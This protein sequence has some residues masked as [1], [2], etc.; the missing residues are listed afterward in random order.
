MS[1]RPVSR[2]GTTS[3]ASPSS[4]IKIT[5]NR[6]SIH[7][8]ALWQL[9]NR[10]GLSH[11][12]DWHSLEGGDVLQVCLKEDWLVRWLPDKDTAR[13]QV[14]PEYRQSP[15]ALR[16]LTEI[17][18][19]MLA[20]PFP[21]E[22]TS[23]DELTMHLE[24]RAEIAQAA[25]KTEM[26]F[27]TEAIHRPTQ[28][29]SYDEDKGFTLKA[30][31]DLVEA[32]EFTTQ[33]AL[34][35]ERFSFSCY[36]ATEYVILLGIS[37]VLRQK[38]PKHYTELLQQWNI[39]P[40]QSSRFH[41]HFLLESGSLD[42]PFPMRFYTPGD[43]VWFKNPDLPSSDVAGYEGSWVIYLGQGKFTN[44]WNKQQPF[45]LMT[46][47]VEVYHWRDGLSSNAVGMATIDETLVAQEVAK[48]LQNQDRLALIA[49]NMMRYRDPAGVYAQGGCIDA[50]RE[51]PI[52]FASH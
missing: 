23:L 40:L 33:P 9:F 21:T 51:A 6:Q 35:G 49:D 28:F 43:R 39:E 45:S 48:T 19:C 2:P 34:S 29:W 15:P 12:V 16:P 50:S 27:H 30:G 41:E 20:N 4:G 42:T 52:G 18:I 26:N 8:D 32:L 3:L 14:S 17:L 13:I 37:K 7:T 1:S 44:F 10:H 24:M 25:A 5:R 46:K 31:Q 38:R 36:R 22:F 47:C 11:I